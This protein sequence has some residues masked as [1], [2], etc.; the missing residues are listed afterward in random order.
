MMPYLAMSGS[1]TPLAVDI[2][3]RRVRRV[4]ACAAATRPR[5]SIGERELRVGSRG[6]RGDRGSSRSRRG[7]KVLR[8]AHAESASRCAGS[9][10]R[11]PASSQPGILTC[12][13]KSVVRVVHPAV[14]AELLAVV[15]E[16]DDDGVVPAS[17][18]RAARREHR[19]DGFAPARERCCDNGCGALV[20]SGPT[21]IGSCGSK[22]WSAGSTRYGQCVFESC[23]IAKY[24]TPGDWLCVARTNS[25][26]RAVAFSSGAPRCGSPAPRSFRRRRLR[27]HV[28]AC[29]PGRT[30]RSLR[31]AGSARRCTRCDSRR[32]RRSPREPAPPAWS[33]EVGVR[34]QPR[35]EHHARRERPG[36]LRRE[37]PEGHP[38]GRH[39]V[40]E[41][42]RTPGWGRRAERVGAHALGDDEQH[43]RP[44]RR[45]REVRQRRGFAQGHAAAHPALVGHCLPQGVHR[46]VDEA[47][48]RRRRLQRPRLDEVDPEAGGRDGE[49]GSQGRS[50]T[51]SGPASRRG[52][53]A[54]RRRPS[55]RAPRRP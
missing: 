11:S 53:R 42:R 44:V 8:P 51:R 55:R 49:P 14:L 17:A 41:A 4:R 35:P 48:V 46:A 15:G 13:S 10:A 27:H 39:A 23:S 38:V 43:V 25:S 34:P 31:T 3:T 32:C 24:G 36:R 20:A 28:D 54:S 5:S 29:A 30:R 47:G 40:E 9:R 26:S 50:A 2:G 52:A 18:S 19:R 7:V 45:G 37:P 6:R 21:A 16:E 1:Q 12:S 33:E 22:G